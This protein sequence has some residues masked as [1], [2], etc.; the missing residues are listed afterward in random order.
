MSDDRMDIDELISSNYA[1]IAV[2]NAMVLGLREVPDFNADKVAVLLRR[3]IE[4]PA[5]KDIPNF[6]VYRL[7]LESYQQYL[8]MPMNK[9]P[10]AEI[11]S[12]PGNPGSTDDPPRS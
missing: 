6:E 8:T 2:L 12:F 11:I 5:A 10:S 7:L 9:G 3:F 4:K 1:L